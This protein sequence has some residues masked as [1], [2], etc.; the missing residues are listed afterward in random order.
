M[1]KL[2]HEQRNGHV[3]IREMPT[4][5]TISSMLSRPNRTVSLYSV[6]TRLW[7][8]EKGVRRRASKIV[9]ALYVGLLITAPFAS[10]ACMRHQGIDRNKAS[11]PWDDLAITR[12]VA[13]A[14]GDRHS[15]D[16]YG[17]RPP[18][19]PRPVVVYL[20]GGGWT[21]G[22]KAY[23]AWVGAAL[24]RQGYVT[25]IPDYRIYPHAK[26]PEFLQDNAAAVRWARDNAAKFGGDPSNLIL[27][28]HSAG[29]Y[30]A[31]NLAVDRRWLG[32][33]GMDPARDLRAVIGLSGV[34]V[35]DPDTPPQKVI[36]GPES[37]WPDTQPI[38][39]VD[40]NAPPLLL[41][42][43]DK[44]EEA[45]VSDTDKLAAKVREK[46]GSISVIHY[47]SL[48]H[49]DTVEALA[50][51]PPGGPDIMKQVTSFIARFQR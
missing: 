13:Y 2:S 16:V 41:I 43:G 18:A 28:G 5:E 4:M 17:Q 37:Q 39:H 47:P 29:A 8:S 15:L 9:R 7:P 1:Q 49:A 42:I 45:D 11:Q 50:P 35:I 21:G 44:D 51:V 34:Y 36:F 12:D 24:A 46:G 40:G 30:N 32:A 27:I 23:F 10:G 19:Q 20:Y 22:A 26:W 14:P 25:V 38:A 6:V 3:T 31:I 48:R 33:V